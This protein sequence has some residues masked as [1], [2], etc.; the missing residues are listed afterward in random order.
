MNPFSLILLAL[1]MSTDAFAAA[2]GK[3]SSLHKPRFSEAL[4]TGL[5]FGVIEAMTPVVG[6][7]IGQAASRFVED[8][9]HWIAFSLLLLLGLHMIHA[10]LRPQREE[11][12]RPQSHSFWILALTAFATSIDALAVGVGL[13]F[14]DVNIWLAALAIGLA[15][16][17]MVTVG[18]MLGRLIGTAFGR[19]AEIVGGLV[20]IGVG[21]VILYEHAV[22]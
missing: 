21:A 17:I 20:L 14:V 16:T 7:F 6:W 4:R 11:P 18:V 10:G 12:S 1:A 13:A 5:I 22:L 19:K 8:W 9:D 2:I 3:G 15:T